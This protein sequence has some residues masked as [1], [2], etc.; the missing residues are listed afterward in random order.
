M[1][2]GHEGS[3]GKLSNQIYL[4]TLWKNQHTLVAVA[5]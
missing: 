1:P 2:D 3:A 5:F 4:G